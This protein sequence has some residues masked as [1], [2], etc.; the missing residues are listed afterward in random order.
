MKIKFLVFTIFG[1]MMT[2]IGIGCF[3][4]PNQV[5][6]GGI[7][8]LSTILYYT[9]NIAPGISFFVINCLLLIGGIKMLGNPFV[10]RTLF[11]ATLLSLFV[12]LFS[13]LP[14]QMDNVMLAAIFGGVLYGLGIG[15]SFASGASTGG[16]D[17]VGRMI[18]KKFGF[19][20][21]GKVLLLIDG[22]I[23]LI[24]T[25]FFKSIE[26]TLYGVIALYI[27]SCS[28][29]FVIS[30][31]N[32]SRIAFVITDMGEEISNKLIA[33]SPRGVT[34]IDVK[35]VYSDM[36]KK[37]LFCALKENEVESFQNKILKI[38]S[39]A[40]IVFSESQGI[41]GNGFYLYK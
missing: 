17:I 20:P 34:L 24:S 28:I 11:G 26:L 30:K 40:F 1:T 41:K 22:I 33:T 5:V 9:L 8:G 19:I 25:L 36:N 27:S 39:K 13:F 18:Q 16:T 35:G 32:V 6:G 31:L 3:L 38:D 10:F 2:G 4:T 23:I 21:I 29:D 37:M 12:Q 14:I 7:S 15:I